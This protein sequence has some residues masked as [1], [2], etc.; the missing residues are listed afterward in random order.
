MSTPT[1]I[2]ILVV[3][4]GPVGLFSALTLSR[5][6]LSVRIIDKSSS[7]SV[8]SKAFGIQVRTMEILAQYGLLEAFKAE[9]HLIRFVD[10]YASG[11][12]VASLDNTS[13]DEE[14]TYITG[15]S[16]VS[17]N[18]S[19]RLLNQALAKDG[20][21]L[22]RG[23]ALVSID[24]DQTIQDPKR[25]AV[26][27]TLDNGEVISCS[28]LIGADGGRSSVRKCIGYKLEGS[29]VPG[30]LGMVDG[31]VESS[32]PF[33]S[34]SSYTSS[35]GTVMMIP[36]SDK[37]ARV[38]VNV[39]STA[40]KKADEYH[41]LDSSAISVEEILENV[42]RIVKPHSFNMS[43]LKWVVRVHFQERM[44]RQ[45]DRDMRV[46]LAGD[47]AHVHSPA[48]G[49]GM[50]MGIQDAYSLTW[51]LGMIHKYG[52]KPAA[53]LPSYS[54]ERSGVARKVLAFSGGLQKMMFSTGWF[55]QMIRRVVVFFMSRSHFVRSRMR[56][57]GK[58][59]L[60]A[61]PKGTPLTYYTPRGTPCTITPGSRAPNGIIM[62]HNERILL[63]NLFKPALF[64]LIHFI[65]SSS[66][67]VTVRP[68]PTKWPITSIT[69]V[70][71]HGRNA[72]EGGYA[73]DEGSIFNFY[74]VRGEAL[75]V[76]R[77]DGYVGCVAPGGE[78]GWQRVEGY[79]GG[80]FEDA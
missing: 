57:E 49:M 56:L 46:F 42:R 17:Q 32:L 79:F 69:L 47:A 26:R 65:T 20:V 11:G 27:A 68:L 2:D 72:Q 7:Q 1:D 40:P 39:D 33:K 35:V 15:L 54:Q 77:P 43:D 52:G 53:L 37:Y 50:N 73:V 45:Y 74:G 61:Y 80:L 59:F 22:E 28:H 36:L 55:R 76:V 75:V 62:Y 12:L 4:A 64:T 23:I 29:A 48:G 30:I 31:I 18:T 51:R 21:K 5:M 10:F 14:Q 66:N 44:V 71:A 63:H 60:I 25:R 19:E 58:G 24:I 9:R 34:F 16:I 3:G 6:G 78:S 38:L 13:P 70:S 41:E 8:H 67:N